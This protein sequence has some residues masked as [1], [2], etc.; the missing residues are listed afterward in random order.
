PYVI[1]LEKVKGLDAVK[2]SKSGGLRIGAMAT[3][4]KVAD[5]PEVKEI[6]PALHK[7]AAI[8]GTPQTRNMGTV[9][10]NVLRASPSG[11][12]ACALLALGATIV[13]EGPRGKREASIDDFFIDYKKTDRKADELAIE[14]KVPAPKKGV[15]SAFN[16]ITRTTLDLSKI[17]AAVCLTIDKGVCKNARIAM[18][19]VAPKTIR[20]VETENLLTG[21]EITASIL[22]AIAASVSGQISP[23][24]DVRSSA[25][26]RRDVSPVLLRRTI[27]E[28]IA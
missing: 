11:D 23:I 25:E 4:Q 5:M 27:E 2:Y 28:A 12:C 8:N 22:D 24:D 3:L 15:V 21:Q 10:G 13:F 26:Y 20:L 9:V 14:I 18:G 16:R 6:Y 7:S 19:A 17:N 1:S